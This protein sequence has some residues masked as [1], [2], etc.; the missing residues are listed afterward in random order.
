VLES[1]VVFDASLRYFYY[2]VQARGNV[3]AAVIL[4]EV[5]WERG[6]DGQVRALQRQTLTTITDPG[7]VKAVH[8]TAG[9]ARA[10]VA[11]TWWSAGGR[12]LNVGGRWW[13][14]VSSQAQRME[15]PPAA[16]SL[17]PLLPATPG[18]RCAELSGLYASMPGFRIQNFEQAGHCFRVARGWPHLDPDDDAMRPARDEL[19]VA[20]HEYPSEDAL[21]R[22]RTSPPPPLA[23]LVPFAQVATAGA[24]GSEGN[25]FL[26]VRGPYAGWLLYQTSSRQG[27]PRY[28]GMPWSTCALWRLGTDLSG[29]N[30][31]KGDAQAGSVA[32]CSAR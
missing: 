17:L 12:S 25:W 11:P 20:V 13:R 5:D 8:Q 1:R 29:R 3:P 15:P 9:P 14:L 22:F 27:A 2:T 6:R 26:A 16:D 4:Q 24:G 23:G 21:A 28:I 18:S 32:V 10:A 30:A 7:A 31:P 19:R